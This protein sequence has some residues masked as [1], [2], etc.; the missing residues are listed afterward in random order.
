MSRALPVQGSAING[1]GAQLGQLTQTDQEVVPCWEY[2]LRGAGHE[3]LM[4]MGW[5]LV[6]GWRGTI[7]HHF[8]FLGF[9]F[10]LS[11][12]FIT[13]IVILGLFISIVRTIVFYF[14]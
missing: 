12:M 11:V 9:I 8:F 2:K 6:K 1:E 14:V 3:Q 7:V 10:S 13:V 4:A 5:T